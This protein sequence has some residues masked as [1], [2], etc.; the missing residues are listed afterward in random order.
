MLAGHDGCGVARDNDLA[1]TL[2][3]SLIRDGAGST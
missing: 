2:P 1:I 3:E